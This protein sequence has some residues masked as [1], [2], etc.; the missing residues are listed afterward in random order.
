MTREGLMELL[1]A[2]Q[3]GETSPAQAAARLSRLPYE[4]A[5]FAKID[6]HRSLRLGLPEVIYAAGKSPAQVAEIFARMAE[7]AAGGNGSVMATR[8][9]AEAFEAALSYSRRLAQHAAERKLGK[10]NPWT[11][12]AFLRR[13]RARKPAQ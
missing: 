5:G 9:S 7:N 8:A 3:R 11:A 1:E 2:I 10:M 6:H 12:Q 4:D 13:T